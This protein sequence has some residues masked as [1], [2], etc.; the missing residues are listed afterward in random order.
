MSNNPFEDPAPS[1]Q[2]NPF[3]NP[4]PSQQKDNP[5]TPTAPMTPALAPG[6]PKRLPGGLMAIAVICLILGLTGLSGSCFG[7]IMLGF[8]D[9]MMNWVNELPGLP[10]ENREFNRMNME[11]QKAMMVPGLALM[12]INLF[13]AAFLTVGSIGVLKKSAK[14][15]KILNFGILA[16]IFY[17]LLKIAYT[18]YSFFG[19]KSS[20]NKQ[21]E[22][23][24]GDEE[25][26]GK[27]E[28]LVSAN[29]LGLI[30]GVVIGVI[31]AVALLAFYIWAKM[32][33]NKQKTIDFFESSPVIKTS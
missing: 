19:A 25:M 23:F 33:V 27:L 12:V 24:A 17:S 28:T 20:L 22:N 7:G 1:K 5:Y 15:R 4:P 10:D 30:I 6:V 9:T 3:E 21:I 11:A 31:M 2:P 32:Y 14:G 29:D 16:A 18:V 13:V 26:T 8:Q